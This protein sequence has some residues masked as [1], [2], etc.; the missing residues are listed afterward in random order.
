[1]I[2][3]IIIDQL[4]IKSKSEDGD[5]P[6][7]VA[8]NNWHLNFIELTVKQIYDLAKQISD[9]CKSNR[10]GHRKVFEYIKEDLDSG[11]LKKSRM[12]DELQKRIDD[13][14]MNG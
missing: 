5:S 3:E 14:L 10:I 6:N 8:N 4:D 11:Y 2:P 7:Q 9:H 1:M 13:K 12:T